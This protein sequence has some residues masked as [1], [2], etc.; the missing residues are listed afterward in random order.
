MC[1]EPEKVNN[2]AF[3][4]TQKIFFVFAAN[5]LTQNKYSISGMHE[6]DQDMPMSFDEV[7]VTDREHYLAKNTSGFQL[8]LAQGGIYSQD[9]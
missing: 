2:L 6:N 1:P 7:G 8:Y 5:V 9:G 4:R 3:G